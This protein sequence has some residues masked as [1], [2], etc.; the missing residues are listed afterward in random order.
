MNRKVLGIHSR[1]PAMQYQHISGT[2]ISM[3]AVTARAVGICAFTNR[4]WMIIQKASKLEN[5]LVMKMQSQLY[6]ALVQ[7]VTLSMINAR[8]TIPDRSLM[9]IT[10]V[11]HLVQQTG[12]IFT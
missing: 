3:E 5:A 1:S 2:V 7:R 6:V 11:F 9:R 4:V 10:T 12:S 8:V